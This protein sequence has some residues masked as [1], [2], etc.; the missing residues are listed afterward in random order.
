M[1]WINEKDLEEILI[2]ETTADTNYVSNVLMQ[3]RT[4]GWTEMS[5]D[6]CL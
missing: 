6:Q 1:A 3:Q 5:A 2:K 4:W